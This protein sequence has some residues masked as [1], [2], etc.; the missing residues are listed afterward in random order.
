MPSTFVR[1]F[2]ALI[3]TAALLGAIGAAPVSAAGANSVEVDTLLD[4]GS[5]CTLRDAIIAINTNSN[6]GGCVGVNV[7]TDLIE[8]T[9]SGTITLGSAL[10]DILD[11]VTI[12]G[13]GNITVDGD[14]SY[15][16]FVVDTATVV[17]DGLEITGGTETDGGAIFNDGG[18]VTVMNSTITNNV[19][20][21]NGGGIY[22]DGGTLTVT[23]ST[24]TGNGAPLNGGGIY[25][26][27]DG[28]ATVDAGSTVS[29][30]EVGDSGGGIY[31]E[32][33]LTVTG[34][35][36]SGNTTVD[37]D[38]GGISNNDG[39]L[40]VEDSTISGNTAGA[41]RSGG[42]IY[43]FGVATITGSTV[44]DNT[45]G[46]DGGGIFED[47]TMTVSDSVIT[48]NTAENDGGGLFEDDGTLTVIRS[49]ISDNTAGA[50]GGGIN[51]NSGDLTVED[52][53]I[54]GN[55]ADDGGGI[56]SASAGTGSVSGS[57]IDGNLAADN[58][59]G[60]IYVRS[61]S[62]FHVVNSTLAKNSAFSAGGGIANLGG[63]L[64]VTNATLTSNSV[65]DGDGGGI[66]SSDGT[67]NLL[68]TIVAG[69]TAVSDD[70]VAGTPD[71][72]VNNL[73][74]TGALTLD[75]ILDPAGLA[76]NGGPTMTIALTDDPSN[77]AIGGGDSATCAAAPVGGVDQRAL[78]R[79]DGGG[80]YPGCDIGAFELQ[81]V[82]ITQPPTD[83]FTEGPAGSSAPL[84]PV[85][86][87]ILALGLV[88]LSTFR[89]SGRRR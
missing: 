48:G 41:G 83:A 61:G 1:R 58:F 26:Q 88:V 63:T 33:T 28:T 74:G 51:F 40:T 54:T 80:L 70:D 62:E 87:A 43:S 16:P 18:T 9:V 81:G 32:G 30:N 15:R 55:T 89:P 22:N 24:I 71:T 31:S 6:S 39:T 76:D 60:G 64:S 44:S 23:N 8:F 10:P 34:S 57:T 82:V 69:N 19:A 13:A 35:A 46:E 42:G 68:N 11:D 86:L 75:D 38:G 37:Q 65:G 12:D 49:T 59:G 47:G 52:S 84:L 66:Y 25:N 72:D 3:A 45:A 21:S 27:A 29:D 78:P 73:I 14:G 2:G 4:S 67:F 17:F 20:G 85:A 7:N 36:I 50:G 5:D 53:A 79:D 56:D 77:P